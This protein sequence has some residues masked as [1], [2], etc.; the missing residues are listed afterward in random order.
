MARRPFKTARD[1][2]KII[3]EDE[4]EFV[5]FKFVDLFGTLQ[6][7]TLPARHV[8]ESTF[9][10]GLGFDG[11]SVRGFQEINESDMV[12]RPDPNS[13]F[14]DPFFDDPTISMFCD[15]IDPIRHAPYS[16]D[17]R[18]VARRAEAVIRSLGIADTAYLG[19]ELEFFVLDDVRY[20]QSTEAGYYF[21]NAEGAFWN[22]GEG[23]GQNLGHRAQRKGAY[24]AAP[25]M[26]THHNLR[27]KMSKV[28][29]SVGLDVEL[30]HHE[31]GAA[32]QNEIGFKFGTLTN[33]ADKA[34]KFKYVV[35]NVARRYGKAATFMPKPLFE[36]NGSGMHVHVSLWK[37][38]KNLFYQDGTYGDLSPM[39]ESFIAGLLE[40]AEALCAIGNPSTNSYRRLV[41]GYEAPIN[42]AYSARNRSACIRIPHTGSNPKA[43]R[44]EFR[45]PDPSANPYLCYA[46]ILMAGV[47][48]IVRGLKAPEPI[49]VDIYHLGGS[50]KGKPIKNTPGSLGEALTAL[51]KDHDFLTRENVFP[52]DLIE[53]WLQHKQK[54]DVEYIALRPHP[55]EFTLYF[56]V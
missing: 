40:H 51:R 33:Q 52:P 4:I 45:T 31:V 49:D 7:L 34:L 39:A 42:L 3:R 55:S 56:D 28:L 11:S 25:P 44:I 9:R 19:P 14:H 38:G 18:G 16:R 29:D 12:M 53:T 1:V 22:S 6:H 54:H 30:H 5:D 23:G 32:G 13:V 48:G 43:K 47:D 50:F 24:F 21:L 20:H 15:I 37:D 8:D 17:P 10:E 26:D 2:L 46:A 41:P 27:N 35:K 36:E